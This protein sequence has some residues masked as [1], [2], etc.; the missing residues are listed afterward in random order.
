MKC[1]TPIDLETEVAL[2]GEALEAALKDP[3]SPRCGQELSADDVFCPSCGAKVECPP[4][5]NSAASTDSCPTVGRSEKKPT[6]TRATRSNVWGAAA[7]FFLSNVLFFF[8]SG[9]DLDTSN[10]SLLRGM[11][12]KVLGYVN[13]FAYVYLI[14][15]SVRRLHDMGLS[16]WWVLPSVVFTLVSTITTVVSAVSGSSNAFF[17]VCDVCALILNLAIVAWLGFAKGTQ[18]PNKYG[19]DPRAGADVPVGSHAGQ[20]LKHKSCSNSRRDSIA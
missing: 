4:Q 17:A 19:P 3:S 20:T 12:L 5:P 16:G 1:N 11:F 8:V 18:G 6:A 14:K 9:G 7:A 13:L 2:S 10:G 15:T